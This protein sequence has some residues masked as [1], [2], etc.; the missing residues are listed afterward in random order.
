LAVFFLDEGFHGANHVSLFPFIA[1]YGKLTG[2]ISSSFL[3]RI[4][5]DADE[6]I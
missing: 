1:A 4:P 5:L 2:I 3:T 6:Q